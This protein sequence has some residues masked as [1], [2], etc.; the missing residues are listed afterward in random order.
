MANSGRTQKKNLWRAASARFS[1][2]WLRFFSTIGIYNERCSAVRAEWISPNVGFTRSRWQQINNLYWRKKNSIST[3]MAQHAM[4]ILHE[5][6]PFWKKCAFRY[7][8]QLWWSF[9]KEIS[10]LTAILFSDLWW[11]YGKRHQFMDT[12]SLLRPDAN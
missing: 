6:F 10:F 2:G 5:N 4:R 8:H 3:W 11:N 1:Y 9:L 7:C 12:K